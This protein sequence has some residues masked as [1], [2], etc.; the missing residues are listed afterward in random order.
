MTHHTVQSITR[1][2]GNRAKIV[3]SREG[4]HTTDNVEMSLEL[5][6]AATLK[7]GSTYT[8]TFDEVT[9]DDF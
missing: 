9:P 6:E 7:V 4:G 5:D 3:L 1:H 8:I 2:Y